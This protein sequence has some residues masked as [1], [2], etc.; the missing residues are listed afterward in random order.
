MQARKKPRGPKARCHNC[1]LECNRMFCCE[2]CVNTYVS[3]QNAHQAARRR[4]TRSQPDEGTG[5]LANETAA[6][7]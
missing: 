1:G 4:R 3:R 2:W 5:P 7:G 6:G